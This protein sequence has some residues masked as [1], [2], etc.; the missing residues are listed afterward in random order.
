MREKFLPKPLHGRFAFSRCPKILHCCTDG[1]PMTHMTAIVCLQIFSAFSRD[2]G[3]LRL[4]PFHSISSHMS[5]ATSSDSESSPQKPL[6]KEGF[7][8]QLKTTITAQQAAFC[9]GGTIRIDAARGCIY[10]HVTVDTEPLVSPPVVIRWDL[11][12]GKAIRKMTLPAV[13]GA[14]D[15]P[16]ISE[17]LKDCSPATFGHMGR[18][19]LDQS[20]RQA[21]KLDIHQFCTSFS[22][23]D[24]G[25]ID[26]IAQTLLPE[27][28][29]VS[30][31]TRTEF[32]EHWGVVAELYKLNVRRSFFALKRL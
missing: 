28:T 22:P 26:A 9:C 29:Q 10:K 11:P 2:F 20:Y 16:A 25:I 27:V 6:D 31:D 21:V 15:T 8:R 13:Q 1:K 14:T 5:S 32:R 7:L 18:E 4:T 19:V 23:H 3:Q 17:L 30:S 12:S 24:F